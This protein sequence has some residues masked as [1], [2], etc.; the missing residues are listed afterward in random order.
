[1]RGALSLYAFL[2]LGFYLVFP[3]YG[4]DGWKAFV[5]VWRWGIHAR[6]VGMRRPFWLL[7]VL[8]GLVFIMLLIGYATMGGLSA[9]VGSA[10]RTIAMLLGDLSI[11][12]TLALFVLV[13]PAFLGVLAARTARHFNKPLWFAAGLAV[14]W[15]AFMIALGVDKQAEYLPHGSVAHSKNDRLVELGLAALA[16]VVAFVLF[17]TV[18]SLA[19]GL[20]LPDQQ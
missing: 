8:S 19:F 3:K 20:G 17:L 16:V 5:P 13:I 9:P 15:P 18:S 1:M 2:A 11:Y 4:E 12:M 6:H 14:L 7:C 10:P